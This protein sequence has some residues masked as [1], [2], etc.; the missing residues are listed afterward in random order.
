[1]RNPEERRSFPVGRVLGFTLVE[2]LVT[3]A[4]IALLLS[5]LLPVLGRA[6][7][8][9]RGVACVNNLKQLQVAWIAYADDYGGRLPPNTA[10]DGSAVWRSDTD[11]WVGPSSAPWDQDS[12]SLKRGLFVRLGYLSSVRGFVCPSDDSSVY[13][14][15]LQ[16]SGL[17]RSRSYSMNGSLGGRESEVQPVVHYDRDIPDPSRLFVFIDEHEDSIDDG[18]FLVWPFPDNRWV[19]LPADRHGGSGVLSFADGHVESWQWME[20]KEFMDRKKYWEQVIN[21]A[22]LRDLRRLQSADLGFRNIKKYERQ[23]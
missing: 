21:E 5:L 12:E 15:D 3:V 16:P 7:Q 23:D 10:N 20:R 6:R 9:A 17:P 4:I 8:K 13:G 22:D 14:P 19:N 1:M 18:H 11:S 2:M